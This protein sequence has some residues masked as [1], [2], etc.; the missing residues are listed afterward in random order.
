[1]QAYY[2][3]ALVTLAASLVYFVMATRVA[4]AHVATGIL[5]PAMTGD[6][7][8]ERTVRAHTNM[9][10]WMPIFL[11]S[12]WLFAIYWSPAWAAGLGAVWIVGRVVYFIGYQSAAAKRL[13]GFFIQ[14]L[15]ASALLLGA[16]GRIIY[17]MVS[18]AG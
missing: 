17:L 16:A 13:P 8:L 18:G 14:A 1:M 11:P 2:G 3:V 5:P 10:E 6:P 9:L 4:R 12:M 15:A 7:F